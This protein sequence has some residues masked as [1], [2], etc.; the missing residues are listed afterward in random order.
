MA[1][2]KFFEVIKPDH[3]FEFI[4]RQH[5]F[6]G[7]SIFLIVVSIA[8]LPIN[9]YWR[10]AAL[11]YS[12]EFR[13]GTEMTVEFDK[14]HQAEEIRKALESSGFPDAEVKEVVDQKNTYILQFGSISALSAVDAKRLEA[15]LRSKWGEDLRKWEV[16]EGGD[17]VY[18]RLGKSVEPKEVEAVVKEQGIGYL[19]INRYGRPEDNTFEIV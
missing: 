5:L 3:N 2:T 12:I 7:L 13:G 19:A 9:H 18:L 14:P 11:N 6:I 4:G 10:G 17:K 8:M 16:S 15:A 1:K